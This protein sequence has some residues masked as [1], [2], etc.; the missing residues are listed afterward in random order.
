M[1][2]FFPQS[3]SCTE[4]LKGF[5]MVLK[6]KVVHQQAAFHLEQPNKLHNQA[7]IFPEGK[8]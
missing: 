3:Y 2:N 5:F 1:R 4:F 7:M 8:I 6:T